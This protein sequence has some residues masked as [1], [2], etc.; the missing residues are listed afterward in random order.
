M[1]ES[2]TSRLYLI[3][4]EIRAIAASTIHYA[5]DHYDTERGHKLVDLAAAIVSLIDSDHAP[6]QINALFGET[7][8]THNSPWIGVEAFVLDDQARLL[9]IQRRDTQKWAL[10]GGFSEVGNTF[11]ETAVIELWEEAGVRGTV[12]QLLGIFDGQLSGAVNKS[13]GTHVVYQVAPVDFGAS[14]GVECLQTAYFSRKDV[15]TLDLHPGHDFRIRRAWDAC[16]SGT[17]YFDPAS[18]ASMSLTM[19]QRPESGDD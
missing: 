17:P 8:L 3:A 14:P 10:P 7:A 19:H 9:L 11:S 18:A 15:E 1:S 16:I 2:T 4:D 13:H 6:E 5:S 12:K